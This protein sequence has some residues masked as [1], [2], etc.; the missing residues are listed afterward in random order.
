MAV[1]GT[2]TR[3]LRGLGF[4]GL[5]PAETEPDA[6]PSVCAKADP[7]A[8]P[9]LVDVFLFVWPTVWLTGVR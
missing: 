8:A 5:G 1:R 7:S 6:A 4:F 2:Y 3:G 9:G